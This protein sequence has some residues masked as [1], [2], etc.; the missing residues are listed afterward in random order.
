M[1]SLRAE[2][3]RYGNVQNPGQCQ[4]LNVRDKPLSAFNSLDR[5]LIQINAL[6]L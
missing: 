1:A 6:K 4:Q 5:I 3:V 2:Q